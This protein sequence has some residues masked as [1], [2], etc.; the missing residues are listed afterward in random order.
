MND[1]FVH[2][3]AER[4]AAPAAAE[5]EPTTQAAIDRAYQLLLRPAADGGRAA[6]GDGVPGASAASKPRPAELRAR[7]LLQAWDEFVYVDCS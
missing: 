1:P 3:Q 5:A 4:L 6:A 2:E 7:V